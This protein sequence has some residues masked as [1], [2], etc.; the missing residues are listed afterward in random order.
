MSSAARKRAG[1]GPAC[2]RRRSRYVALIA[3]LRIS[4]KRTLAKLNA[5]DLVVTVALGS[6]L[7]TV[8]L[9]STV[10]LVEGITTL[11][12]LGERIP[13]GAKLFLLTIAIGDDILAITVIAL[14]YSDSISPG[15][16]AERWPA[17]SPSSAC[18]RLA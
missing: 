18:A 13:I 7:A 2:G 14:A 9:S 15:W 5:L 10:A 17:C 8:L 11:A 1:A 6:T 16:L 12:L 4:G 3:L